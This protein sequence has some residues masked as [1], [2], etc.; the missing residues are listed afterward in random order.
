MTLRSYTIII[1]LG[2]LF[3]WLAW[4]TILLR[5]NPVTTG[6]FGIIAFYGSLMVALCGSLTTFVTI[7]RHYSAQE[8]D[9]DALLI[10]SIR[11]SFI[12]SVIFI[13]SL[14]LSS[15]DRLSIISF[16]VVLFVIGGIEYF[17][18]KSQH[19]QGKLQA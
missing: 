12:L 3:A 8:W 5:I 6:Q 18:L 11:Q 9:T 17:L 2:S 14:Y 19:K 4:L 15:I 1:A 16:I 13:A 10:A 7:L